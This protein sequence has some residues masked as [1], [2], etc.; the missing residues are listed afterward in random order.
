MLALDVL[1]NKR[2]VLGFVAIAVLL[3]LF[4]SIPKHAFAQSNKN[5]NTTNELLRSYLKL[6][7]FK[8]KILANNVANINT[9]GYKANEVATPQKSEDLQNVAKSRKLRLTTTSNKHLAGYNQQ[10]N[11]F[12]VNKLRDPDELKPNGNNVS[13]SQQLTKI[14]QNQINYDTALQAYKSSSGLITSVLGK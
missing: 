13:L 2:Y 7:S 12:A 8:H 6:T 10:D 1:S 9:P 4:I 5:P 11:N 14:S 3:I